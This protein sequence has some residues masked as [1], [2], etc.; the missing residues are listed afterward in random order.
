MFLQPF[1]DLQ[2]VWPFSRSFVA[3]QVSRAVSLTFH[4]FLTQYALGH[5]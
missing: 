5:A 4:H 3:L 1:K 2:A